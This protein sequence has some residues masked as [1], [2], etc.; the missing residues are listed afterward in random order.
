MTDEVERVLALVRGPATGDDP[1]SGPE[2]RAL[3]QLARQASS[4]EEQSALAREL[5]PGLEV[6]DAFHAACV[7]LSLGT[8]VEYGASPAIAGAAIAARLFRELEAPDLSPLTGQY[9]CLATMAHLCR[10]IPL[11]QEVRRRH[12]VPPSLER[13]QPR[14]QHTWFVRTVLQ[15]TDALELLVLCPEQ[16]RGFL[17]RADGVRT[18]FHLFTLLQ[19]ALIGDPAQGWLAPGAEGPEDPEI[20]AIAT[21]AKPH[22]Q[23]LAASQRFHFH[24]WSAL[25]P[26]ATLRNDLRSTVWGEASPDEIPHHDGRPVLLLGRPVLGGRSWDTNFFAN[27][28]DA[29]RSSITVLSHLSDAELTATFAS[30]AARSAA[31]PA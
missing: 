5:A 23:I 27:I 14:I 7:A 13:W 6:A 1:F 28:H 18:C 2:F 15:L 19:G 21:G 16:R 31:L 10:D 26:D 30:L 29:L 17:V 20:Y 25:A 3:F 24:D 12:G 11:R 22:L 4:D 8:L 9:L